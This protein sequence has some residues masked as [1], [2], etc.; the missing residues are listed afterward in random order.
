MAS[1]RPTRP[2]RQQRKADE[3]VERLLYRMPEA[4]EALSVSVTKL[5]DLVYAGVV[6]SIRLAGVLRVPAEDLKHAL[7]RMGQK[8]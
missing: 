8:K 5:Y 7:R 2:T 4:A 6:P 3:P 1:N